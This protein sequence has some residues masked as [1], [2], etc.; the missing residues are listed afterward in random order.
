MN[1]TQKDIEFTKKFLETDPTKNLR[2]ELEQFIVQQCPKGWT[3]DQVELL[4]LRMLLQYAAYY[5]EEM[6]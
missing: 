6:E 1:G 3:T 4:S 2:T 5:A